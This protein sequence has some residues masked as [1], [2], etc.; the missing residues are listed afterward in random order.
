MKVYLDGKF[1][2]EEEAK[3][4]IFDHGLLYGDGIFEGIRAYNGY[5]FKLEEHLDRMYDSARG[6]RLEIPLAR[7]E[8][9]EAIL[10]TLRVNQLKT[11]YV[12]PI[13]TRG[14]GD[15]GIDPRKCK[16]KPTVIVIVREWKSLYPEE[17]YQ[18]GL[19]AIVAATR[20]RPPESLSPS[21]K[22]LNY[23][24]NIM[25]KIEANVWG[26]DEAIML[27]VRGNVAEG[28]AD[29]VFIVKHGVLYTPPVTTNLPGITRAT[30]I[31][32]AHDAD[33]E[34]R[35]EHFGIGQLYMAD[36]VFL[37]GTAAE[38][39]P[40]VEIDGRVIG[41]GQPGHI[42]KELRKRYKEITGIPETGTPIYSKPLQRV[43]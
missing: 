7:E 42:T 29:N 43:K 1:V 32:L 6:I 8:M 36:E 13:V 41:S 35:E 9:K 14:V 22:T 11:S 4:S 18:K 40:I 21:I 26:A 20:A 19:R 3:V 23:L 15:L 31:E 12:R 30:I 24:T 33:Y 17:H 5:V 16:A 25:A 39:V 2:P 27:D 37:T 34:V 38:V 10:E 28:T